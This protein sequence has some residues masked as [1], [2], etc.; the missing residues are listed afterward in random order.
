MS[1]TGARDIRVESGSFRMVPGGPTPDDRGMHTTHDAATGGAR[2]L[3]RPVAGRMLGGV[4]AA[5]AD[6][7]DVDVTAVRIALLVLTLLGGAGVPLYAA[8]WLLIPDDETDVS[9]LEELVDRYRDR[10][11]CRY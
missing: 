1:L 4:A 11:V 6:Y 5:V 9:L 7:L 10:D 3:R 2:Y 8:G